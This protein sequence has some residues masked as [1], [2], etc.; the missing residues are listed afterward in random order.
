MGVRF[1]LIADM[2]SN[3]LRNTSGTSFNELIDDIFH[4]IYGENYK[5]VKQKRDLGSDG[6][7][8]SER[9]S[10]ACYAPESYDAR[11]FKAKMEED[12]KKF[13]GNYAGLGYSFRFITNI[14]LLG[15]IITHFK[16]LCP[17]GD[18]WGLEEIISFI[19]RQPPKIRRVILT[20]IFGVE[21]EFVIYDVIEE[22]ID[23]IIM[24]DKTSNNY[25]IRYSPPTELLRKIEINFKNEGFREYLVRLVENLYPEYSFLFGEVFKSMEAKEIETLKMKVLDRTGTLFLEK[26]SFDEVF[27]ALINDFSDKYPNDDEYR[28]H[29]TMLL[30]Y[31]FEQC[32]IG[33]RT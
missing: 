2:L 24:L 29:V 10:I 12:Y 11:K 18:I 31:I 25:S 13:K 8:E 14:K 15:S 23:E 16:E 19:R 3:K 6:I 22:M 32:I 1:S 9:I 7:I 21:K 17:D 4:I 20:D 28:K 26:N 33:R 5:S 27:S 30:I